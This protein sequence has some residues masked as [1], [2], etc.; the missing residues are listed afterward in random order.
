M[1]FIKFPPSANAF[2]STLAFRAHFAAKPD[3][4]DGINIHYGL[5]APG[6]IPGKKSRFHSIPRHSDRIGDP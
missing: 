5:E 6:S 3:F 2:H 1:H 4:S